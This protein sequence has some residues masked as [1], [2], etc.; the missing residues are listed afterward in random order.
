MDSL[1]YSNGYEYL[2]MLRR[3]NNKPVQNFNDFS[4]YL[5]ARAR[6][7]GVPMRGQ[8]ELTPLCNLSCKMCYVHLNPAQMEG[9]GLL[10]VEQWKDLMRQAYDAGMISATLTGGECL[11]YP[12]F[13]ELYL[14]LQSLGC[15]VDVLTNGILLTEEKVRFFQEH[16]PSSIQVTLYGADDEAYE[17]V[18]GRRA[19]GTVVENIRRVIEADLPLILTVTPSNSLGDGVFETIRLA[20]SLTKNVFVNTSLFTPPGENGRTGEEEDPDVQMYARILRYQ[21][22]L[23][24][25][26]VNER[27]ESELPPAGGACTDCEFRGLSCGG[28]R[29]GFV[30]NWK[31][32]MLICNRM[33]PKSFP[34]KDGFAAAWQSIHHAAVNWPRAAAC[35]GCPYEKDCGICAA[36]ALKYAPPGEKPEALCRRTRYLASRGV[37]S[38]PICE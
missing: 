31:G 6:E 13:E 14:Y 9:N 8:F 23:R 29:S 36:E 37:I 32:E 22:V 38:A 11:T 28:G 20:Y 26:E 19:C 25:I 33:E 17:R 30:I 5:E 15:V 21:K 16:P 27:P 4:G 18:T 24:G 35:R 7:Q 12:G 3:Q 1:E 2:D 34:F 10:S